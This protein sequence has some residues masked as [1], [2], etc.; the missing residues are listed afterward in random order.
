MSTFSKKQAFGMGWERFKERPWFLVG[1][2]L[3]TSVVSIISGAIVERSGTT[4]TAQIV[5]SSIDFVIQTFIGMGITLVLLRAYDGVET[6]Y[7]DLFEP[8]RLFW[9]YL[10]MTILVLAV[11]FVGLLLFVIPGIIAGIALSFAPYLV[12]DKGLGPVD[13]IK[14]SVSL[15]EGHRWNLFIFALLLVALNLLGLAALGVGLFVTI[16][17]SAL[18]VVHVYRWLLE[19]KKEYTVEVSWVSKSISALFVAVL[20]GVGLLIAFGKS[21]LPQGTP[22]GRDTIR[23]EHLSELKL[24]LA[25]FYDQN[26]VFPLIL[27]QIQ[28]DFLEEIPVDP[29]TNDFYF[30][31][32]FDDGVDY[33]LCATLEADEFGIACEYGLDIT[34]EDLRLD[35]EGVEFFEG[36][37]GVFEGSEFFE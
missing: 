31:T 4:G 20:I 8:V 13:A 26:G 30:Y 1:L 33:E 23:Q 9:K 37:D 6:D 25:L 12:I 14:R 7:G 3:I 29:L 16:P 36:V 17:I 27:D 15:T 32:A 34:E 28:P 5:L 10:S 19:P 21:D 2:F 18:A 22:L 24:S 11:V 35:F